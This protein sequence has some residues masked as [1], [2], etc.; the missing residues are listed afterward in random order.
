VSR[1]EGRAEIAMATETALQRLEDTLSLVA[2]QLQTLAREQ[3]RTSDQLDA[4]VRNGGTR[5]GGGES[6]GAPED[7]DDAGELHGGGMKRVRVGSFDLSK[8]SRGE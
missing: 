4:I 6:A 5:V 8:R 2:T 7:A 1:P 3:Q